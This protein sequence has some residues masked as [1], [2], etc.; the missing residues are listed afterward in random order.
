MKE[1]PQKYKAM[2]E[3]QKKEE[4]EG[5]EEQKQED[6]PEGEG[7]QEPEQSVKSEKPEIKKKRPST[8]K[9]SAYIEYKNSIGKSIE[10]SILNIR[11]D[12]K[13][14]RNVVKDLTNK[15]NTRKKKIDGLQ[16][17]IDKKDE[18]RKMDQKA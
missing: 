14:K 6:Q 11:K 4:D 12:I 8:D 15:C 18:E 7:D 16:M 1:N 13:S 17:H 2:L 9:Q 10:D 3:E 5:K